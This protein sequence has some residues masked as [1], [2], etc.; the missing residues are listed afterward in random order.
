MGKAIRRSKK[1]NSDNDN[2]F[3]YDDGV[4]A[5]IGPVP[6]DSFYDFSKNSASHL[7]E[8]LF[9]P[10]NNVFPTHSYEGQSIKKTYRI[11]KSNFITVIFNSY[12]CRLHIKI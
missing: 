4:V 11:F 12:R 2:L 3:I 8:T 9:L 6:Y 10:D 5:S 7:T 1:L